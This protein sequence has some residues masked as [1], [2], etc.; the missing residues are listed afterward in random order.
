LDRESSS[1]AEPQALL[2]LE[3]RKFSRSE[4]TAIVRK[5]SISATNSTTPSANLRGIDDLNDDLKL[6]VESL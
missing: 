3:S 2:R 4:P 5:S 1:V 6:C